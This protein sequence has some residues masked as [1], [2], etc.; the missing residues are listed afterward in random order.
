VKK[1]N[2]RDSELTL[3]IDEA[4]R[5]PILGPMVLAAVALRPRKAAALT[6]AG[7]TD[8]KRFVGEQAHA[9]R[10][11]LAARIREA[12]DH[13]ALTVVDV[14]EIDRRCR[15]N[16]LNRLEQEVADRLIRGA[17]ACRRIVCDGRTLFAPLR[18]AHANLE[19]RDHGELAHAAVAAASIVAKV[20]RDELWAKIAARYAPDFGWERTARGGYVNAATRAF[21]RAYVERHRRLPP[22]ARRSWPWEFARDLL[23]PDFDPWWDVPGEPQLQLF[24]GPAS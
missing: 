12:A 3:G 10:S 8:S 9:E 2:T 18:V 15:D 7:V 1:G 23:S 13:V 11:A 19:A 6:R 17:P 20:R 24:R 21:L 5:G 22:E 4:G 16:G 14:A